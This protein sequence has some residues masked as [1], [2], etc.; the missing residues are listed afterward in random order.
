MFFTYLRRELSR[1]GR[2]AVFIALGLALGIGRD[3]DQTV[4]RPW[5]LSCCQDLDPAR[6]HIKPFDLHYL[7]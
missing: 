2:Q 6:H 3:T 4:R 5:C 7:R 1:R